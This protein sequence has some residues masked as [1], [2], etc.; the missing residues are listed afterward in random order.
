HPSGFFFA[1]AFFLWA[2]LFDRRRVAWSGWLAGTVVGILPML[3]WL[4]HL[5]THRPTQPTP[6]V[7]WR[8]IFEGRFWIR[9]VTES[10]GLGLD[11]SLFK[12]FPRFLC[13]PVI[14]GVPTYFV[15]VL[16]A[17]AVGIL[18]FLLARLAFRLWKTCRW[19]LR[20]WWRSWVGTSCESAF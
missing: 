16:H 20:E 8:H 3:P 6:H 4:Y 9:W 14:G 19:D 7:S 13:Y 11:Y 5:H 15:G 17:L 1:A 18:L 2:L 10:S 12:D